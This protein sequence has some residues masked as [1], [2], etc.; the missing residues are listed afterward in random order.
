MASYFELS[1]EPG[2][3]ALELEAAEAACFATGAI[4]VTFSDARDAP[5]LEPRPGEVRFWPSTRL[6]ALYRAEQTDAGLIAQLAQR[7]GV[8]P[9]RLAARAVPDRIWER[10][11]LRDFHAMRF[12][13]RLWVCP[14][15]E[16]VAQSDA[17]VV[18]LDP[19]LAFG[20]GTHAST[21][22]CLEWL[23]ATA[24]RRGQLFERCRVID[25]GCGS[26]VLALAA[27]KLGAERAYAFDIDPQALLAT[28][29]NAA[30]NGV[31]DRLDVCE[32]AED[33]PRGCD[34]LLANIL[35]TVLIS[36]R[37][38]LMGL[39]GTGAELLL[40]GLL[41]SEEAEMAGAFAKWSDMT[42]FAQRDGWVALSGTRY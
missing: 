29:Q 10:E 1:F 37:E 32:R 38:D 34:L 36:L 19:G 4:A 16:S 33:I 21:S 41:A 3:L 6:Q 14:H 18:S 20:T 9:E 35:G 31:A 17:V 30:D 42:R 22:L 2:E 26:G 11:W 28:R 8:Q 40:S 7:L 5:V 15:H 24:R 12:G 23:D 25:Y 13:E 27:L 39:I